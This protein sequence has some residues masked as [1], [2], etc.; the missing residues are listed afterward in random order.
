MSTTRSGRVVIPVSLLMFGKI[1]ADASIQTKRLIDEVQKSSK[2]T[3]KAAR[4]ILK[5]V[6]M[7]QGSPSWSDPYK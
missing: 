4:G 5:D 6:D 3:K 7:N 1:F 2:K